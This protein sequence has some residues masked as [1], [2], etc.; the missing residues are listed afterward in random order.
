MSSHAKD[1]LTAI[2]TGVD[3]NKSEIKTVDLYY[4]PLDELVQEYRDLPANFPKAIVIFDD[5]ERELPD[6]NERQTIGTRVAYLLPV[7]I[8]IIVPR[9]SDS[10][11]DVDDALKEVRDYI[12]TPA[13]SLWTA[14]KF[15]TKYPLKSVERSTLFITTT[16]K[17]VVPF[18]FASIR[19]NVLY[20]FNRGSS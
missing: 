2:S 5:E 19:F 14:D 3:G 12:D 10:L 4:K 13:N 17:T 7:E 6:I 1:I 18:D 15:Q 20:W 8:D 9:S 11:G 16:D